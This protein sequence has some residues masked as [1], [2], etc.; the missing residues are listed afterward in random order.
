M[1]VVMEEMQVIGVTEE[2]RGDGDAMLSI[3][4][5]KAW[6]TLQNMSRGHKNL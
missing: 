1:G 2:D 4:M 6:Y 5:G 3:S